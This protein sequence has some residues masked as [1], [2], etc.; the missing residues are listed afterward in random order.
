MPVFICELYMVVW[1]KV[2]EGERIMLDTYAPSKSRAII[3]LA[4]NIA[5]LAFGMALE[6]YG[7]KAISNHTKKNEAKATG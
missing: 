2:P 5:I 3:G 6:H 7:T 1:V 4:V